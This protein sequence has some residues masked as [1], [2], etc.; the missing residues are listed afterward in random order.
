[1]SNQAV[2][3]IYSYLSIFVNKIAFESYVLK[4][5]AKLLF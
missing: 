4:K 3:N 1:M 2:N 5:N